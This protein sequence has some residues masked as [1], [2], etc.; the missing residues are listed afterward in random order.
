MVE[1]RL[2]HARMRASDGAQP[3]HEL[4][5]TAVPDRFNEVADILFGEKVPEIREI[6]LWD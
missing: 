1:R 6:N 5:V 3:R 4:L 2:D